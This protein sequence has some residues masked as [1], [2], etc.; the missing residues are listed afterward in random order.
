MAGALVEQ[1]LLDAWSRRRMPSPRTRT[2]LILTA[3]VVL[4][5]AFLA[6]RDEAVQATGSL[7]TARFFV[8]DDLL[9]E[10]LDPISK[11]GIVA[12][13]LGSLTVYVD[14]VPCVTVSLTDGNNRG[15]RPAVVVG[16]PVAPGSGFT[17]TGPDGILFEVGL[18]AQPE[19][20]R[21]SGALVTFVDGLGQRLAQNFVFRP[22]VAYEITSLEPEPATS[23]SPGN[24]LPPQ[25]GSGG[26][27][28][29]IAH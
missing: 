10:S 28:C 26:L 14:N 22:G 17:P 23:G 5:V 20:C 18:P 27:A 25:T 24:I 6:L 1:A 11:R 8:S 13:S 19:A 2:L 9:Q 29:D 12:T 3:T 4:A 21:T 7:Q 16:H 15:T